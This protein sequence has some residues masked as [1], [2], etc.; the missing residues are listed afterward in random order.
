MD[1][2]SAPF[3]LDV[4]PVDERELPE[5]KSRKFKPAEPKSGTWTE[6]DLDK[7]PHGPERKKVVNALRQQRNRAK[8]RALLLNLGVD[9]A[10]Y[11]YNSDF[12]F[13]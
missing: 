1:A 11:V 8:N 5:A 7:L 13:N 2:T 6:K 4:V 10:E 9:L 3:W 12:V